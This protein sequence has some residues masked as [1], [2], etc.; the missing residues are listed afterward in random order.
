MYLEDIYT[1]G[2]NLAGVPAVSIPNCLT[3]DGKPLGLQL[4]GPQKQDKNVLSVA[5]YLEK[6][7]PFRNAIP[8]F[9]NEEVTP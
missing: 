1:I 8:Q 2:V 6:V 9:V 4:I 7:L 5:H 3:R